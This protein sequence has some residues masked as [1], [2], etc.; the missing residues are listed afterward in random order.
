MVL[1]YLGWNGRPDD[2][3]RQHGK[4][5]AQSPSGLAAVFNTYVGSYG[6]SKRLQP[7]T[8]G[9]LAGLRAELDRG[10]PVIVHGYFTSYGHVLV[11]LGY[12]AG[13]YY[14]NDP[15]GQWS[16]V[17]KGGY[18]GGGSGKGAYYRK[19][20]FEAAVGTSNGYSP[21]ALWYHTLR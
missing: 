7:N 8:Q 15:A 14:V 20:A 3:T 18:R 12:D 2:V 17:F 19:A 1:A 21:L 16:E 13:G 4:R 10:Q 5:K 11:V 6:L 9:T